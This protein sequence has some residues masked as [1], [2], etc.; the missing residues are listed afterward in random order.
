MERGRSWSATGLSL[1]GTRIIAW[2]IVFSG[3]GM[4]DCFLLV[5]PGVRAGIGHSYG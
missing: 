2:F 4:G 5:Y 1:W 3:R